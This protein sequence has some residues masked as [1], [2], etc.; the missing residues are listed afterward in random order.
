MSV[1]RR[2]APAA[3]FSEAFLLL[4]DE[5]EALVELL[6]AHDRSKD[7]RILDR[8]KETREFVMSTGPMPRRCM[9]SRGAASA[10]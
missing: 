8:A 9:H 10:L 4:T 1:A 6:E 5:R 7:G 3:R 2:E